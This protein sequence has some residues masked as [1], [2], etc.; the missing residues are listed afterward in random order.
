MSG[1]RDFISKASAI[2][3]SLG[4]TGR[5]LVEKSHLG[6]HTIRTGY[7]PVTLNNFKILSSGFKLSILYTIIYNQLI[8]SSKLVSTVFTLTM[9]VLLYDRKLGLFTTTFF[10]KDK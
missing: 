3:R 7:R 10:I 8:H 6:Q 1:L 5:R 4:E 9:V 2:F